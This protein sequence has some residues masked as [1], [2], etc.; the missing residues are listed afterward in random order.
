MP[1]AT[2]KLS[3]PAR[4]W[5]AR[6]AIL[7]AFLLLTVSSGAVARQAGK[8]KSAIPKAQKHETRH[9]IDQL[10][11]RW[12]DAVLKSNIT[13]MQN[14]LADDYLAITASGTL[15]TKEQALDNLRSG[16]THFTS[17]EITDRK[18]RFYG[19]TA[20]VTSVA[21]VQGTTGNGDVSGSY[22]YTRVYVRDA[23]GAWK[24]VSFEVSRIREPGEHNEH[25]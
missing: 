10:E 16:R 1:G 25:K 11:D 18:V 24:V 20:L 2:T 23:Q 17:L 9:E 8:P 13:A 6:G 14:L 3:M 5:R 15:Q 21:D 12:R 19:T 22:R 4:R 7:T